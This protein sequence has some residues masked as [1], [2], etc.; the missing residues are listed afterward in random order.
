MQVRK[1][2]K[3]ESAPRV[4]PEPKVASAPKE[5]LGRKAE[6]VLKVE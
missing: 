6:W 2:R 1:E 5:E 3:V 4:Q